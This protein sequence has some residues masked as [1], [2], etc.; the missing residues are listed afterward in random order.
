MKGS[1]LEELL[2]GGDRTGPVN[3]AD[4]VWM[5]P[6]FGNT[7]VMETKDGLVLV[8]VPLP[9]LMNN[10][11]DMLRRVAEGPV[12]TVFLTHGHMDHAR[13]LDPL[14]EEARLNK[15]PAPRVIAHRNVIRRFNRYRMLSGYHEHINRIQFA[16]P[17]DVPAFPLPKVN[18]DIVFDQTLSISVGGIDIHAY[19]EL[20]ETDDHLWVWV[21]EKKA[22]FAGDMVISSIPNVGNP[23]KVQRYTL[24]WAEGLEAIVGRE[25]EVLVP[26]H[27]PVIKGRAEIRETL[28]RISSVLRYLHDEVVKRLNA[29]MWYE[30]ILHE[31]KLPDEMMD[32][33]FL[34]PRYGCPTFIVHGILRQYTGWYDG[35]PSNLFPPKRADVA[36]EIAA[37]AGRER[38]ASRA[39]ELGEEGREAMA[40][41]LVDM[42]LAANPDPDEEREMHRLKGE[43]LGSLGDKE[44]SF[45][46]RNI[47]YNGHNA[48]MKLAGAPE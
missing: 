8:D 18:P 28:L 41:Q 43:L 34:A 46:A 47:L 19:H 36:K 37:L 30:D 32:S 14:F 23:I 17:E 24:E 16:V 27:G 21:P 6:S 42:V 31:V 7:G 13:S 26:G 48:E 20:G 11:M 25:P 33:R 29:G 2:I 39:R 3:P 5:I 12:N 38:L 4:G 15:A 9:A 1:G 44:T 40:L 10:T 22:V 35:N 45:I